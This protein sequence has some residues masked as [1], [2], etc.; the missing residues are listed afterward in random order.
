MD[1]IIKFKKKK[2]NQKEKHFININ[3]QKVRQKD[4]NNNKS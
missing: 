2:K 4:F 3:N 1:C